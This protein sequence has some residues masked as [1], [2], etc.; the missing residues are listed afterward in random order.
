[1]SIAAGA[2]ENKDFTFTAPSKRTTVLGEMQQNPIMMVHQS[3]NG[4]TNDVVLKNTGEADDPNKIN[5]RLYVNTVQRDWAHRWQPDQPMIAGGDYE[6][7]VTAGASC[8]VRFAYKNTYAVD[9]TCYTMHS[10]NTC[11]WF[12]LASD[13]IT[14]YIRVLANTITAGS[15]ITVKLVP[16]YSDQK[17]PTRSISIGHLFAGM[18]SD[19]AYCSKTGTGVLVASANLESANPEGCGVCLTSAGGTIIQMIGVDVR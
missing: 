9:K 15:T 10:I 17:S 18:S 11:F 19:W 12:G 14:V 6:S 13:E 5:V 7:Q 16:F 1:L 4:D 2:T 3:V 8:T